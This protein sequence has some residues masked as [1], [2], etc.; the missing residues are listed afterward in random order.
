MKKTYFLT[1]IALV[2]LAQ[3]AWAGKQVIRINDPWVREAPPN[4]H[5]L[6]AY[7]IIENLSARQ[8]IL[9]S[10]TS[11]AFASVMIHQTVNRDGMMQMEHKSQLEI[12]AQSKMILAP[13]GYH[14][15][16]MGPKKNIIAGDK[17]ALSLKFAEGEEIVIEVPVRKF[18]TSDT[19]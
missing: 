1:G 11:S 15:M 19:Q 12:A 13:G 17:V 9:T 3:F 10:V 18:S 7:M 16:L 14:L 5:S 8:Q 6:A 4:A 2:L